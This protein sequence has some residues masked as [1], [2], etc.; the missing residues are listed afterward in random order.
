MVEF[1]DFGE[2]GKGSFLVR[3]I[4]DRIA[5]TTTLERSGDIEVVVDRRV[6]AELIKVLGKAIA[7]E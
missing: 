4:G 7:A 3:T 2:G 5:L 6:I 1:D